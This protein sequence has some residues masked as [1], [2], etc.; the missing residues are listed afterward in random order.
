MKR[1]YFIDS[2]GGTW[3]CFDV[4]RAIPFR[5]VY[6]RARGLSEATGHFMRIMLADKNDE[7]DITDWVFKKALG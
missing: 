7:Q 3:E 4:P 2:Q 6:Q 5:R 1:I